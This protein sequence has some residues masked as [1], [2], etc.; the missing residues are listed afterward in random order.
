M[1]RSIHTIK[2]NVYI[3][4][5][6][7]RPAPGSEMQDHLALR[8]NTRV[9]CASF[10]PSI[11]ICK[12]KVHVDHAHDILRGFFLPTTEWQGAHTPNLSVNLR[13]VNC[14]NAVMQK[15]N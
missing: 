2:H 4:R 6:Y 15:S 8:K 9:M 3:I 10:P 14:T 11:D 7:H 12:A 5:H 13:A 1:M